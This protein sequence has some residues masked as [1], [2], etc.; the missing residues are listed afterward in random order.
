MYHAFIT[1]ALFCLSA[2]CPAQISV[3][4]L[5]CAHRVNPLGVDD[6][7]PYLSWQLSGKGHNI[8]QTAY[9]IRL[10]A[11]DPVDATSLSPATPSPNP[12]NPAIRG[13]SKLPAHPWSSG[14]I[15]SSQSIN[16]RYNGPPLEPATKYSWQ[17][18][19][20]DNRGQSS[21]WS[22]PAFFQTGLQHPSNWIAQ[23]ILPGFHE[24]STNRP[25][26]VF[27][28]T[29]MIEKKVR[30]A[31]LFIT[32]HGLYE[33]TMNGQRIGNALFTP[34][35]TS[36]HRRL[37]YQCYDLTSQLRKGNNQ[38]QVTVGDGWWRGVF[39]GAMTHDH[40]GKDA[41]LLFQ[42]QIVY[43]DGGR[44]MLV[45]DSSW[46]SA[47]GSIR[48]ADLYNGEIYDARIEDS[49]WAGVRV[50]DSDGPADSGHLA[51]PDSIGGIY[52]KNN[53]VATISEPVTRQQTLHPIKVFTDP[54]GEQLIDFG[55]NISGWVRFRPVGQPGDTITITHAEALDKDGNF[56]TGNL[57]AAKAQDVYI[58]NPSTSSSQLPTA[59]PPK[60][61]TSTLQS[62]TSSPLSLEPHF[63]FHGFRYARVE[64][65]RGA[66]H[67]DDFEAIALSSNLQHT[68]DF[69]CSNP[70]LNQLQH[71]IVWS[72]QD[73][74][75]DIPTDCPQR[76]ERYGWTG[77]AQIFART[78]SF[79]QDIYTFF[80]K[81][82]KDLAADQ[83]SNG[84]MP[85]IIPDLN[86]HRNIGPK[87]GVAGWGDAATIVP[88]T[89]FNA[90]GDTAVL[91]TQYASMKAWV[92]YIQSAAQPHYLWNADGYGDWLAPDTMKTLVPFIDQCYYALSTRLLVKAAGILNKPEDSGYYAALY[93]K[94]QTA[95]LEIYYPLPN[96]QTGYLLPLYFDLLPDSLR[97]SAVEKLVILIRNNQDH[98]ATG[99]LGTPC[100]LPVL[101]RYG[102]TDLAYTVLLQDTP[103]SWLYPVKMGATTIWEKWD[104][105]TPDGTV[106]D[107]SLNHYAYG[108]VGDWLYR[109]VAGISEEEPGY[110]TI[111][112]QPHPG[113]GLSF[114]KAS[115]DCPYGTIVSSWRMEKGRFRLHVEIPPNTKALIYLPE[116][117]NPGQPIRVGSGVYDF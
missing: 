75:L 38:V 15:Y 59:D 99:F 82:L 40:Y 42:L 69:T 45:S 48:Y 72:Q 39:G 46:Q 53:L 19:V 34:G 88:W 56:Y 100:L 31:T 33:A 37:Q 10:A 3:H 58:L 55:Q 105:I 26:P 102:Y 12:A 14:K 108:A 94:V 23:W 97:A 87:K 17:V 106:G 81:W 114:V 65:W 1:I 112:I 115:Y 78:A 92:D 4:H 104:A 43:T 80:S 84:G 16:I 7:H 89:L 27:R 2:Y 51:I 116:S 85:V 103:P 74:F 21:P 109:E 63:T 101:T 11:I 35:W 111:R 96:T 77:D 36:Y 67:P 95:L 25:P 29:F 117:Q 60:N 71:N 44:G 13:I 76:S 24:D 9:E 28:K 62:S 73:N 66:L 61:P 18:R 86:G 70:L 113:G 20:W 91:E 57:R 49:A 52:A 54:K 50:A 107:K 41:A 90:Y 6:P 83:G 64:G 110:R 5:R 22:I 98:L 30:F 32:A 68:G 93:K 47:T 8:Q 79:N